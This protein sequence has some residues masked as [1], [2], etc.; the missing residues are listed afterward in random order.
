MTLMEFKQ[1][2]KSVS[3]ASLSTLAS[4]FDGRIY[5][6]SINAELQRLQHRRNQEKKTIHL[7]RQK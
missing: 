5:N 4:T 3:C 1:L 2:E 6:F 7:H